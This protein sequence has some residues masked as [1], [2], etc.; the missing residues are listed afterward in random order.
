MRLSPAEI[1][2]VIRMQQPSLSDLVSSARNQ[3]TAA[4]ALLQTQVII[5]IVVFDAVGWP[6]AAAAADVARPL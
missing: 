5:D 3:I 6:C 4:L 1:R 2:K